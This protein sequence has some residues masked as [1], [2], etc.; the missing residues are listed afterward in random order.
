[1]PRG[2]ATL[3]RKDLLRQR[4]DRTGLLVYLAAPL[5]LTFIM[6]LSF[7]GGVFGDSGIS[8]IPVAV[9]TGDLPAGLADR[10]VDGLQQTGLFTVTRTDSTTAGDLV[11]RGDAQAALLLPDDLVRRFFRG[12]K[13]AVTLWKDPNSSIK[14]GIVEGALTAAVSNYQAREAAYRALW[15]DDERPVDDDLEEG[16]TELF[17]GD[18]LRALRA[19]RDDALRREDLLDRVERAAAFGEAVGQP[20]I[21]LRT[22]DRQDWTRREDTRS[23]RNLYDYFLPGLAVFFM[24]WGTVAIVRDLHREREQGTMSRLLCGPV[25]AGS[26][27]A[28]KWLTAVVMASAQLL[29]LLL[30]GGLLFGV[31]VF[32]APVTLLLV[33]VA[34]GGASASVYLLLGMLV[35][36]E[37]ALDAVT[38][39]F[40]LV[41]G[42]LGGNFFPLEFMP[43]VMRY[44]G[45]GTFNYW[46]NRAF[47][48]VITRGEGLPGVVPE[49]L[50]LSTIGTAGLLAAMG[51]F[52]ARRRRGVAA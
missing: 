46:A 47:A 15:P 32:D 4:R 22:H 42:M 31:R 49:L 44:A 11:R 1:M 17:S 40:T 45:M 29:M 6:G 5:V 51:V 48:D 16:F 7:G 26:I 43:P 9:V 28:G 34:A 52:A 35:A 8:A 37:K 10:L 50:V 13:V 27:A 3:V 18:V 39:V 24:M 30:A 12:E 25:S 19:L 14:A 21:V 33:A 2:L 20:A 38:T 36:S 41:C 23:S